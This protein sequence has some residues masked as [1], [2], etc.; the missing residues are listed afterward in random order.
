MRE[1]ESRK[2][3]WGNLAIRTTVKVA[4]VHWLTHFF[5]SGLKHG[6]IFINKTRLIS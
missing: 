2:V 3:F 5:Y 1:G 4:K 6:E